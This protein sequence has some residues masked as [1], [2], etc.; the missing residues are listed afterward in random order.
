MMS[1]WAYQ[2]EHDKKNKVKWIEDLN[3]YINPCNII[4]AICK[5]KGIGFFLHYKPKKRTGKIQPVLHSDSGL[6]IYFIIR[7]Y[8]V[9]Y[10][11]MTGDLKRRFAKHKNYETGDEVIFI[12][13][14]CIGKTLTRSWE[15]GLICLIRPPRNDLSDYDGIR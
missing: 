10:I 15:H 12:N 3:G 5:E 4:Q 1:G 9:M 8:Q 11:G 14:D 7:D 6:G 2:S 13:T